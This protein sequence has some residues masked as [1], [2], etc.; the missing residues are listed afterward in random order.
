MHTIYFCIFTPFAASRLENREL[1]GTFS[2]N[3]DYVSQP[4]RAT[5]NIVLAELGTL[6]LEFTRLAQLTKEDKYYDAVAR[7]TNE[8]EIWQNKTQLPGMWPLR[9]DGSGCAK[10]KSKPVLAAPGLSDPSLTTPKPPTDADSYTK[11]IQKRAGTEVGL[12]AD[13]EPANYKGSVGSSIA[14]QL[15]PSQESLCVEVGLQ[16]LPYVTSEEFGLGA[17]ADSTYEYLPKEYMLLGGLN[18][19][20]ASMYAAAMQATREN[21]V[22]RPMI[23]EADRDLRFI[24]SVSIGQEDYITEGGDS[25]ERRYKHDGTHLTCFVGGM[26]AIASKLFDIKGDL[27]LASK[28]TDACVW[29]Y[30]TTP[31]G[32][33]PEGFQY[34]PCA[35]EINCPWNETVYRD[36]LDP[37]YEGR[38][39]QAERNYQ[40]QVRVAK[41][42]Y[43][44]EKSLKSLKNIKSEPVS[45]NSLDIIHTS[46]AAPGSPNVYAEDEKKMGHVLKRDVGSSDPTPW[47]PTDRNSAQYP[48]VGKLPT[49]S[50]STGTDKEEDDEFVL[51][52]RPYIPTH[53]E[54]AKERI[55]S[56]NLP[57]G[58]AKVSGRK[59]ILRPEA[60]ESVFIMFRLTGDNYWR[61]KGWKMF[62]A[63]DKATRTE[64]AHSAISDVTSEFPLKIDEMESFW[65]AETLKYFYLLFADPSVISLDE[66][67]L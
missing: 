7:I 56:E 45:L 16:S 34:I 17:L 15:P 6:S 14:S 29:A 49:T 30:E 38:I 32:I 25:E 24:A 54:Y 21:L 59:Y 37:D 10:I 28:L 33:M 61:E 57:P 51:P 13:A 48:E 20:Y 52:A 44:R 8:L 55:K 39:A 22:F 3:R 67:V 62:Q 23:K 11:F 2:T 1:T 66:Y 27:D 53:E 5:S 41:D 35:D 18:D 60:I 12:A 4:H 43:D 58:M 40:R 42:Y 9:V 31:S 64:I 47:S 36:I 46:P 63:V 50:Y 19:Q 65:L 26:F